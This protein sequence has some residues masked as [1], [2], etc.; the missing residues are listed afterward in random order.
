MGYFLWRWSRYRSSSFYSYDR[1]KRPLH[2]SV[3]TMGN[4]VRDGRRCYAKELL[5]A[6]YGQKTQGS[7]LA[8][9]F[10]IGKA[11]SKAR[12]VPHLTTSCKQA[13]L[14]CLVSSITLTTIIPCRTTVSPLLSIA[15][16]CS[17][18]RYSDSTPSTSRAYDFLWISTISHPHAPLR[19]FGDRYY[20]FHV[21]GELRG[22][23]DYDV[24]DEQNAP[25][26][27]HT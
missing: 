1:H 23:N 9:A 12:L 14:N 22:Q 20:I 18:V 27:W 25:C 19:P 8:W 3:L 15:M 11:P 13:H 10:S 21:E 2:Q 26:L 5:Q 17:S 16:R 24:D 7:R 4:L 6:G